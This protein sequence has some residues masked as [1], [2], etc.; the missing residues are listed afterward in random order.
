MFYCKKIIETVINCTGKTVNFFLTL[1]LNTVH[2]A[3]NVG[4][5]QSVVIQ[6]GGALRRFVI[7]SRGS[8]NSRN[9]GGCHGWLQCRVIL[10]HENARRWKPEKLRSLNPWPIVWGKIGGEI[11]CLAWYLHRYRNAGGYHSCNKNYILLDFLYSVLH[12]CSKET[13]ISCSFSLCHKL[14]M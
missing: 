1:A 5:L 14:K 9:N 10:V 2:Y 8:D 7:L 4:T 12:F 3:Q 13:F 11:W 6:T